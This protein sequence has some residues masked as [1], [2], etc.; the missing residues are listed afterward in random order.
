L[1]I[2]GNQIGGGYPWLE[3]EQMENAEIEIREGIFQPEFGKADH[4]VVEVSWFG[5]VAYCE[6]AGG[7]LPTEAEW[8]YAARGPENFVYP[9]GNEPPTCELAHFGGCGD[10]SI[11]VGSLVGDSWVGAKDMAGNVWEHTIDWYGTY[12]TEPQVNPTGPETGESQV[13]RGGSLASSPDTLHTAYRLPEQNNRTP[14]LGFRCAVDAPNPAASS[15]MLSPK[16]NIGV[17]LNAFFT[18]YDG[19]AEN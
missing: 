14:Q 3:I 19:N 1:N 12:P 15:L 17:D 8:E 18:D 9:W 6:W 13:A 4:P 7:R 10:K 5:A 16:V 11:P 2:H